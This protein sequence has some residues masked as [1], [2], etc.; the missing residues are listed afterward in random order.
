[1]YGWNVYGLDEDNQRVWLFFSVDYPDSE[2][3]DIE[4]GREWDPDPDG[5]TTFT[6]TDSS[7][8]DDNWYNAVASRQWYPDIGGGTTF[9]VTQ[10]DCTVTQV[11]SS[12][13]A[14]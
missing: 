12:T 5:G 1:V 3:T 6:Q 14:R 11:P 4:S 10:G 9:T 7:T 13:C 2:Y 8:P